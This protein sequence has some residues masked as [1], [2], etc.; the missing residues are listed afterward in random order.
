MRWNHRTCSPVCAAMLAWLASC[1]GDGMPSTSPDADAGPDAVGGDVSSDAD[2]ASVDAAD[3][4]LGRPPLVIDEV[5]LVSLVDP[6]I[7]TRG[8]GNAIPGPLLPHGLIRPNPHTV[9]GAG[10]IDSYEWSADAIQGFTHTNLE[11][12]GGSGYGYSQLLLMPTLGVRDLSPTGYRSSFRHDTETVEPGYY[13]VTLDDTAIRVELTAARRAAIHRYTFPAS[14]AARVVM[15]LGHSNG[16]S[17]GGHVERAGDAAFEG[18]ADY[19]VHPLLGLTLA[20]DPGTTGAMRVYFRVEASRAFERSGFAS[21]SGPLP[22]ASPSAEGRNLVAFAEWTTTAAEVIELRVGISLI[23]VEHARLNLSTDL[24]GRDFDAVRT[25]ARAEWNSMLNRVQIEAPDRVR[26]IFYTALYHSMIQPT[27]ATEADGAFQSGAGG[28]SEVFRDAGFHFFTDDW[29]MWDT[30]RTSHPLATLIEPE[31]RGPVARSILLRYQQGGWLPKCT[32]SAT[33]Y[34]RVMI[35]NHAIPILVDAW[36]KGLRDFDGALA[37]E[38]MVKSGMDDNANPGQ[39]GLCGYFNL[40]TIPAYVEGGFVPA[41]CDPS[42]AA[43]MTLE[44]AYDDWVTARFAESMGDEPTR[45]RF[46]GRAMNYHQQWNPEHGFMQGRRADGSWVEPFDAADNRDSNYF[47]EASSW[48]YSFFVP[49]DVPGLIALVGGDDAFIARLDAFF[50]G[51]HYDP[52]NQPSFH[53]P[54]LYNFAGA[55]W[56]TQ[57]RVRRVLADSYGDDP[58]GLPGNDDAG[59]MSAWYVLAALGLYPLAPGDPTWQ[60]GAPLVERATVHLHP[61]WYPGEPLIIEAP[62]EHPEDRYVQSVTWRG[63]PLDVPHISHAEL[64]RGGTLRVVLG[65]EPSTWGAPAP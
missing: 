33:G 5:D 56:R 17:Q 32:W 2:A 31:T 12:P 48:I 50:D 16:A 63:Q 40:G 51:G 60:L 28:T 61:G 7:G 55:P 20:D 62:R 37:L 14:D 9:N 29:C 10:S 64:V 45:A 41:E 53:I 57:D 46:D 39:G 15:D 6:R 35:G 11:G 59:S 38:A 27:D 47:A 13:A 3:G 30:F 49:H 36:E 19:Q 34:S 21:P 26:R 65:P 44:Y 22:E 43:S 42:Q 18:Y 8:G 4:D 58:G 25:A 23:D 52:S 54:W 24:D 1:G